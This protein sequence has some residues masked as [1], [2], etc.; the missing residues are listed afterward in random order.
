MHLKPRLVLPFMN[1]FEVS[2]NAHSRTARPY[3]LA[4]SGDSSFCSDL[5]REGLEQSVD[6]VST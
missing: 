2:M 6:F 1:A 4:Y 3:E 5:K